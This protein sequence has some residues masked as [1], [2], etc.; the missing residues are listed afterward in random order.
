MYLATA[1]QVI[2]LAKSILTTKILNQMQVYKSFQMMIT[3][4]LLKSDITDSV[5][6]NV[7]VF[8]FQ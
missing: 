2:L 8:Y 7:S 3:L 4:K 1:Q 6:K 5:L